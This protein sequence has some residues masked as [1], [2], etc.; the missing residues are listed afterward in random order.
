[1]NARRASSRSPGLPPLR[2]SAS[3]S[4]VP[5][6]LDSTHEKAQRQQIQQLLLHS[7]S[8]CQVFLAASTTI[9]LVVAFYRVLVIQTNY[10]S[11]L[12]ELAPL[13]LSLLAGLSTCIG[14]IWVLS[15]KSVTPSMLAFTS[16]VAASVMLVLST[17]DMFLPAF[18]ELGGLLTIPSFA[19][20]FGIFVGISQVY[21]QYG[22]SAVMKS[23]RA[24]SQF[25]LPAAGAGGSG[26]MSNRE[27]MRVF[28]TGVLTMI[29]LTIHNLPEGLAVVAS[30]LDSTKHG[31][32]MAL[33][34]A[35]HNIPEGLAIA[36]PIYAS[37]GNAWLALLWTALSG[38]SEPL[39]A[40][41]SLAFLRD[42]LTPTLVQVMLC[43][44]GG[45]MTAVSCLE[46]I[47]EGLKYHQDKSHMV[48][49]VVLGASLM[50]F[51]LYLFS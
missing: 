34:V 37:S 29:T 51:D 10:G 33:A 6:P 44:V 12:S 32:L 36:T 15:S 39:G 3:S 46:L 4:L 20:G 2:L 24:S 43:G 7:I 49:G 14:G 23:L 42:Y 13:G 11:Q 27:T 38:M 19:L 28:R 30:S 5:P 1:M 26:G 48:K 45:V 40:L 50:L 35:L 41:L 31:L 8:L 17:F 18:F 22:E 9:V 25:E 21:S 47:P 16:G